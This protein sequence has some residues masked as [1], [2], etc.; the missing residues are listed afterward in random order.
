MLCDAVQVGN[1]RE[2]GPQRGTKDTKKAEVSEVLAPFVPFVPLCGLFSFHW[3]KPL[4]NSNFQE[5]RFPVPRYVS[6]TI[7]VGAYR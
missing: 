7:F 5:A 2:G 1:E 6:F 4:R 3:A